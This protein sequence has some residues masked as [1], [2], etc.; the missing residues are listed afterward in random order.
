MSKLNTRYNNYG[1]HKCKKKN[2]HTRSAN[3]YNFVQFV[4]NIII[5]AYNLYE[6]VSSQIREQNMYCWTHSGDNRFLRTVWNFSCILKCRYTHLECTKL[7]KLGINSTLLFHSFA[8]SRLLPSNV[9]DIVAIMKN[10]IGG[11][12]AR[13]TI[14]SLYSSDLQNPSGSTTAMYAD[15]AA[16]LNSFWR[17]SESGNRARKKHSTKCELHKVQSHCIHSATI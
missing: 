1:I 2:E 12:P 8:R 7:R 3:W 10:Q 6:I 4:E 16:N 15:D 9:V 17:Q 5:F 11:S 13:A 14:N